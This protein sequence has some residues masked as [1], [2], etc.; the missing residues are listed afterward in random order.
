VKEEEGEEGD[1]ESRG[2]TGLRTSM[3]VL[4]LESMNL[5][6]MNNCVAGARELMKRPYRHLLDQ[7]MYSQKDQYARQKSLGWLGVQC[8]L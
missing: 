8:L 4:V 1:G 5:P 2:R 6:S 7:W 3:K